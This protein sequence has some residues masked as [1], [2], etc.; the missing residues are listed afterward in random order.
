MAPA[1]HDITETTRAMSRRGSD[2]IKKLSALQ[3]TLVRRGLRIPWMGF[4]Y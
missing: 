1:R 3:A 2:D 4:Q